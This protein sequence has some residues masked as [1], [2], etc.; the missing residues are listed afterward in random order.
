MAADPHTPALA[1]VLRTP[2]GMLAADGGDALIAPPVGPP[3]RDAHPTERAAPMPRRARLLRRHDVPR[4]GIP[5]HRPAGTPSRQLRLVCAK[6]V[7]VQSIV[8]IYKS[9]MRV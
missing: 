4:V 3:M 6:G 1:H 8:N 7:W 2:A 5:F 9:M